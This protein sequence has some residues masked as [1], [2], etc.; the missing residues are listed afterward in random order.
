M[1][2]MFGGHQ[3]RHQVCVGETTVFANRGGEFLFARPSRNHL[4]GFSKHAHLLAS[5]GQSPEVS[6]PG[7]SVGSQGLFE[8]EFVAG[9]PLNS[10]YRVVSWCHRDRNSACWEE[11]GGADCS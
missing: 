10:I 8:I 7:S 6:I 9:D 1:V 2:M 11:P 4:A 5:D 3:Q